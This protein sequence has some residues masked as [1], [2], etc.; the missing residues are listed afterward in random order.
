MLPDCACDDCVHCDYDCDHC[1][2]DDC[3][4][5]DC[6]HCDCDCDCNDCDDCALPDS[7]SASLC[8]EFPLHHRLTATGFLDDRCENNVKIITCCNE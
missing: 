4:H 8:G 2:C 1:D 6:D 7:P 5:C 3:A